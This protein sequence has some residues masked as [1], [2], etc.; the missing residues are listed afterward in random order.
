VKSLDFEDHPFEIERWEQCCSLCGSR[1]SFLD[2]IIIDDQ[3]AR[4]YLCSDT[5]YCRDRQATSNRQS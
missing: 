2:E 1:D 5:D 3:G 4:D